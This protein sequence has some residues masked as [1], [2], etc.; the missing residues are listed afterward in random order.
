M[1]KIALTSPKEIS[2]LTFFL[3]STYL[4][5]AGNTLASPDHINILLIE[6][7]LILSGNCLSSLS[8]KDKR[9]TGLLGY[10]FL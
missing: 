9:I 6:F 7:G 3:S 10:I 4:M 1:T 5:I 2:C 8:S